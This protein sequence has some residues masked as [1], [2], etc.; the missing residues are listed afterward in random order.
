MVYI[1]T[2]I[3]YCYLY[4]DGVTH[5]MYVKVKSLRQLTPGLCESRGTKS[6]FRIH[7]NEFTVSSGKKEEG[8]KKKM[9]ES[10]NH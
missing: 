10:M 7:Q 2:H 4:P 9:N 1:G 3:L 8:K 6:D 5:T